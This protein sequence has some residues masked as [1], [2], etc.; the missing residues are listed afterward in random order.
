LPGIGDIAKGESHHWRTVS[1]V[2]GKRGRTREVGEA[3]GRIGGRSERVLRMSEVDKPETLGCA[4][5]SG[6][7]DVGGHAKRRAL[8][9]DG[10]VFPCDAHGL[11]SGIPSCLRFSSRKLT[12]LHIPVSLMH[13]RT[14]SSSPLPRV[15]QPSSVFLV[16]QAD[17]VRF[18]SLPK[19]CLH[20][21]CASAA[22][23]PSRTT[24]ARIDPRWS[25][26]GFRCWWI[27]A[28]RERL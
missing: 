25:R 21:R 12:S 16:Q 2:R 14:P 4:V 22:S 26:G 5:V 15:Q 1:Y 24:T 13:R 7:L 18:L 23:S 20:G 8:R 17:L 27:R 28:G 3:L 9:A 6:E 11:I 19:R 10:E